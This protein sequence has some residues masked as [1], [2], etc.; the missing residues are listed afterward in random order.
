MDGHPSVHV[1]YSVAGRTYFHSP[2]VDSE[3]DPPSDLASLA[4]G[5]LR[6]CGSVEALPHVALAAGALEAA[7]VTTVALAAHLDLEDIDSWEAGARPS[8]SG[9]SYRCSVREDWWSMR[10][11]DREGGVDSD[12]RSFPVVVVL[13]DLAVGG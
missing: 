10:W 11:E 9:C 8:C 13:V 5:I 12:P 7:S 3:D 4:V 1:P 2:A 6:P